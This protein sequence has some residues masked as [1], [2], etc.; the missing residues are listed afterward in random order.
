[1]CY[2]K[3]IGFAWLAIQD[4]RCQ[5]LHHC[6]ADWQ[7]KFMKSKQ[8]NPRSVKEPCFRL[9]KTL[10]SKS[11]IVHGSVLFFICAYAEN[12]YL[13]EQRHTILFECLSVPSFLSVLPHIKLKSCCKISAKLILERCFRTQSSKHQLREYLLKERCSSCAIFDHFQ[14]IEHDTA[15]LKCVNLPRTNLSVRWIAR[16]C[17]LWA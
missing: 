14:L 1:M 6:L 17:Q 11:A 10:S 15:S 4:V 7:L 16:T 3:V 5:R 8:D 12:I 2:I 13:L 9:I